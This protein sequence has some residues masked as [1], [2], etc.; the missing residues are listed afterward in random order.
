[1]VFLGAASAA[2]LS[3]GAW[4][5][6]SAPDAR[7]SAA[8]RGDAAVDSVPLARAAAEIGRAPGGERLDV[9][10]A[11]AHRS[12]ELER[13]AYDVSNPA[14][15]NYRRYLKPRQISRRFGADAATKRKVVRYLRGRGLDANVGVSG[16]TVEARPTVREAERIFSTRLA[17]Y[18]V[19]EGRSSFVAPARAA[20]LPAELD[21]AVTAVAGLD[22]SPVLRDADAGAQ[23]AGSKSAVGKPPKRTG[24]PQGCRAG[25]RAGGFTPNQLNAAYGIDDLQSRGYEGQGMEM[26]VFEIDGFSAKALSTFAKC[27]G[28]GVPGTVD[29]RTVGKVKKPLPVGD[30]TTLDTEVIVSVAPKLDRLN[31]YEFSMN[32]NAGMVKALEAPLK[33]QQATGTPPHP[34][35]VSLGGCEPGVGRKAAELWDPHLQALAAAGFTVVVSTGDSGAAGCNDPMGGV[36]SVVPA[37]QSPSSSAFVT[38]VGGTAL[39]LSKKNSIASETV[40]NDAPFYPKRSRALAGGGGGG[41]SL[42]FDMPD[43]QQSAG[44]G[45]S[46]GRQV[47]DISF[48]ADL[49]PGFTLY[50]YRT[51]S[52]GPNTGYQ[53]IG[54]TSGAA[55]LFAASVALANQEAKAAGRQPLGFVNPLIYSLGRASGDSGPVFRDV[56]KGTIDILASMGDP[57]GCCNAKKGFDM[58]SGWGSLDLSAFSLAAG[59]AAP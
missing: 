3:A 15:P 22:T 23:G 26:S 52:C 49:F 24:T 7:G 46:G 18:R 58:A 35:S 50:C 32:G 37:V 12:A 29:V 39:E 10:L 51:K 57:A 20:T 48:Y 4:A 33:R 45:T 41:A 1:M 25:K 6:A 34:I 8:A 38:A 5:L 43:Y 13:F 30:E 53:R 21:G 28:L 2:A 11:L 9:V 54:G 36:V 14:S 47:P 27:F 42:I 59:T 17:R 40:W 31:I 44:L 55:P 16:L 56:T 19:A